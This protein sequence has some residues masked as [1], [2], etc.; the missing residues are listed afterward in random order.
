MLLE[1]FGQEGVSFQIVLSKVD[2]VKPDDIVKLFEEVRELMDK[3]TG[4]MNAGLG[5]ILATSADPAKKGLKKVGLSEL[6][7]AVM[8]AA[9]LEGVHV[10]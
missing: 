1:Q 3:G 6:R 4:G 2:R 9:G 7:W 5:E 10:E 8:V